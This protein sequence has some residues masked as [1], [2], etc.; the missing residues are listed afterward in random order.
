[1][2]D[3]SLTPPTQDDWA[4]EATKTVVRTVDKVRDQTTVK[5]LFVAKVLVYGP[6]IL[7]LVGILAVLLLIAGIRLLSLALPIW[8]VYLVLGL[9]FTIAG[10]VLWKIRGRLEP[11]A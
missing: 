9:V 11:V 8:G 6:L 2:T 10:L 3:S 5:A 7:G 1:M 4:A